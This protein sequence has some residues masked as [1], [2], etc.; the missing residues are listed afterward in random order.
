MYEVPKIRADEIII[1]LRKSRA[2][3]PLET[4]EE[5]LAKHERDVNAYLQQSLCVTVP[6]ELRFREVV[7]GESLDSRPE[8]LKILRMVEDP[9]IKAVAVVEPERLSRG[10]YEDIGRLVRIFRYTGTLVITPQFTYD[11]Q[12]ERDREMF[13]KDLE[14]GNFYYN[15]VG[16]I[17]RRGRDISV[18]LGHYIA[19]FAPYGYKKVTYKDGNKK[20]HTLEP[21]PEEAQ[22]IKMIF[23]MY[24]HGFGTIAICDK[25]EEEGFRPSR[26]KT[27][28]A[29]TVT[30]I[31]QNEHYIGKVR[32][33]R[34]VNVK[35]IEEGR[36]KVSRPKN[37]DYQIV[38]GLH[39]PLVDQETWDKAQA[40][41]ALVPPSTK[42]D[43][44]LRNP[45]AGLMRCT[46]GRMMCWKQVRR[47]G[48]EILGVPRFMCGDI[49]CRAHSSAT[50]EEVMEEVIMML[51]DAIEDFDIRIEKKEDDSFKK[52]EQKIARLE[53][54]LEE[55]KALEVKQWD[56]KTKGGMPG[57]VFAKLNEQTVKDI[58]DTTQALDVARRTAPQV[59]DYQERVTTFRAALELLQD[60]DAPTKEQNRLLK[61]C[62]EE[63]TY[64][65][66]YIKPGQGK[67]APF[68]LD[69]TLRV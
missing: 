32:W 51:K 67:K 61:L 10:D 53:K 6:E 43:T 7:S 68:H 36:T 60:P 64:S 16:K 9:K 44:E 2:D 38:D 66:P 63:I 14:R 48:G 31:L 65:R 45:L 11:L 54:R 58:E 8:M 4:I 12:D 37:T 21:H 25:L 52:H 29:A 49:R 23:D 1:Y 50:V 55:L 20:V 41:R 24:T 18:S 40:I 42:K 69:Y 13:I 19:P 22:A 34:R 56:E 39:P 62:I 59:I 30:A 17:M 3:D 46:C 57:H 15:Y 27:W 5:T 47:R 33:N 35:T 28:K 26:S